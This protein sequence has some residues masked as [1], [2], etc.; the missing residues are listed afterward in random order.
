VSLIAVYLLLFLFRGTDFI[1]VLNMYLQRNLAW[2]GKYTMRNITYEKP[3]H[4]NT[5]MHGCHAIFFFIVAK[6]PGTY[7]NLISLQ[8]PGTQNMVVRGS[9]LPTLAWAHPLS[10]RDGPTLPSGTGGVKSPH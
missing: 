4:V 9:Q 10:K 3:S 5:S 8:K 1:V 7:L 2:N 6:H